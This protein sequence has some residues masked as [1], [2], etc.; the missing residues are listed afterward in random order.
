MSS[1]TTSGKS[2][3]FALLCSL[4]KELSTKGPINLKASSA[5][6]SARQEFK[7]LSDDKQEELILSAN[8]AVEHLLPLEPYLERHGALSAELTLELQSDQKG[9]DGDVRDIVISNSRGW[10]IGISAK[11]Q[12]EAVKHSRISPKIDFGEKWLGMPCSQQYFAEVQPVF[13]RLALLKEQAA[14]WSSVTDKESTVYGVLLRAF[15]DEILRL[16]KANPKE[17]AGALAKY[18][19]G[20]KDFYKVM[21]FSKLNKIQVFNFNGTLNNSVGSMKTNVHLDRLKLPRRIVELDFKINEDDSCSATTMELICDGGWQ[22]AFR[23]HNA[24]SKVETSLKFDIGLVG[25]PNSLPT[26]HT[27]WQLQHAK[28]VSQL[29]L[30]NNCLQ[31]QES[32]EIGQI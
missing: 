16:D 13:A 14:L 23:I 17:V 7:S 29:Q 25:R 30:S 12:H 2:Y 3:E 26:F 9:E 15:R 5:L 22:I 4:E 19:I 27:L 24:S 6:L 32:G 11:H 1:Q 18:L 31:S 28:S 21:K 20:N 8:S 10:E